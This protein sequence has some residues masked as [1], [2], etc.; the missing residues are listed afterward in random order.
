MARKYLAI[1]LLVL[2][3]ARGVT[4]QNV[5]DRVFRTG[6]SPTTSNTISLPIQEATAADL[7]SP[8]D[9]GLYSQFIQI[10]GDMNDFGLTMQL[11]QSQDPNDFFQLNEGKIPDGQ[12]TGVQANTNGV[13]LTLIRAIDRET[14]F[15]VLEF[16]MVCLPRGSSTSS[17]Y[18]YRIDIVD[19]NDNTPVFENTPYSVSVNELTPV[20]TTVF[21]DISATDEDFGENALID[22]TIVPGD[23][24]ELDGSTKFAI[25]LER[26]GYV[27]VKETLDFELLNKLGQTTYTM[28]IRAT[29]HALNELER[30]SVETSFDVTITDGDDL[31]PV[32]DYTT[33]KKVGERCLNP[34]Y[35]AT[36]ITG[37]NNNNLAITPVPADNPNLPISIIAYGQDTLDTPILFSIAYT[38]PTGY[39]NYFSV[40]TQRLAPGSKN[41]QAFIQQNQ[42]LDR[43]VFDKQS[44]EIILKAE[45]QTDQKRFNRA[46]ITVNIVLSNLFA[47]TLESSTGQLIGQIEEGRPSGTPVRGL[48]GIELMKFNVVDQDLPDPTQGAYSLEVQGTTLFVLNNDQYLVLAVNDLDYEVT[49]S[50][51][52][53]IVVKELDTEE[54]LSGTI[55]VT[56][57]VIDINDNKPVFPTEQYEGS[58]V[59]GNYASSPNLLLRVTAT[60]GDFGSNGEIRY[61]IM[62]VSN[63]GKD[64]FS[65]SEILGDIS[66][67]G[68]V[69]AGEVY[70][71]AV[72]AEDQAADVLDR[73][74]K[75]VLVK[76][77]V[78]ASGNKGPQIPSN[79]YD[80]RVSE[81]VPLNFEVITIPASDPEGDTLTFNII[82]FTTTDFVI[83]NN[84]VVTNAVLLDRERVSEYTLDI[85]V[86]D[87]SNNFA[88][89][90]LNIIVL[91]INDNSPLFGGPYNFN[92]DE[93]LSNEF[94]GTVNAGDADEQGTGR[95]QV[96]YRLQSTLFT[97]NSATGEIRTVQP[98]DYE[99]Q[100][101]HILDVQALDSA[102]DARS[103]FVKVTVN[104]NDVQDSVPLFTQDLYEVSVP[105]GSVGA[106]VTTVEAFDADL[107]D[108]ISYEFKSGDFSNF[109]IN[110]FSGL[111]T[112]DGALDFESRQ[113]YE[114]VVTTTD[115]SNSFELSSSAIV[116]VTV[117]DQNDASP[118]ISAFNAVIEILETQ[119]YGFVIVDIDATDAD[120]PNTP[121]SMIQYSILSVQPNQGSGYF[122]IDQNTGVLSVA[123]SLK[124][125]TS[126]ETEY[127]IDILAS[128]QGSPKK[129][130]SSTVTVKVIRNNSPV[131]PNSMTVNIDHLATLN[132]PILEDFKATDPDTVPP[133]NQ[134]S[135]RLIGDTIGMKYFSVNSNTG[136][137]TVTDQLTKETAKTFYLRIVASDGGGMSSTGTVTINVDR[138]LETPTWNGGLLFDSINIVENYPL[139]RMVYQFS[140]LDTDFLSP[141]NVVDYTIEGDG[142]ALSYFMISDGGILSLAQS[143]ATTNINEF[144][145]RVRICD[146]GDPQ[147]CNPD[148]FELTVNID[149]NLQPP[150]YFN[151]TYRVSVDEFVPINTDVVRVQ[152]TDADTRTEF[153]QV[154]YSI[155]G[156]DNSPS[157]FNI[158]PITGQITL[159]D[160][161]ENVPTGV[162]TIVVQAKDNG[163]PARVATS[164]VYV[165]VNRNFNNPT[166]PR[167][168]Y[169]KE[170]NENHALGTEVITITATDADKQAP[171]NEVN[172]RLI[173]VTNGREYF[174]I[175]PE[176]GMISPK[177]ALYADLTR[178]TLYTLNVEAYDLGSPQR[179]SITTATVEITVY[180]NSAPSFG[181]ETY[182]VT[183]NEDENIGAS[184]LGL[185]A[186]DVDSFKGIFGQ[187]SYRIIGLEQ[188]PSFFTIN[189]ATG[190]I[191]LLQSLLNSDKYSFIVTVEVSD[192][193]VPQLTDIATVFVT[194]N[195]NFN[196][197][198]FVR[199]NIAVEI[200]ELRPL[201]SVIETIRATDSDRFPPNNQVVYTATGTS[202]ALTYF[203]VDAISGDISVIR[204]LTL[205]NALTYTLT[206]IASDSGEPKLQTAVPVTVT[207]TV[208][209]NQ[210]APVFVNLPEEMSIVKTTQRFSTVFTVE[211]T[212]RDT[213]P[214]YNTITYAIVSGSGKE[215]FD[216]NPNTG[217]ITLRED[218]TLLS[219]SSYL[220]TIR[221]SDGGS[222]PKTAFSFLTF[223]VDQNLQIPVWINPGAGNT[224]RDVITI[225]ETV[226]FQTLIYNAN[227][228]DTD[229]SSPFNLLDYY[230]TG[231]GNGPTY[232]TINPDNGE[233]RLKSSLIADTA[234]TYELTIGVKDRGNPPRDSNQEITLTINV[235]R[236]KFGPQWRNLPYAGSV[237]QSVSI[238]DSVLAVTATDA[239]TPLYN[240]V[241]Y[242]IFGDD[243]APDYFEINPNNGI[244]SVKQK[245]DQTT[246][247]TFTLRVRAVDNGVPQKENVTTVTFTINHNLYPPTIDTTNVN[248]R[249][250]E[251]Q[252]LGVAIAKVEATDR[253][254][255]P[256]HNLVRYFMAAN[257]IAEEF[258]SV[259]EIT[260]EIT[261][262]KSLLVDVNKRST[263]TF[264]V[265]VNDLGT[266]VK[267][268]S[269]VARVTITVYRNNNAPRFTNGPYTTTISETETP[270]FSVFR[271][272]PEDPDVDAPFNQ[273]TLETIGDAPAPTYFEVDQTGLVTLINSVEQDTARQY[274]MRFS[275]VDGGNPALRA[276][277]TLT[278]IVERN[279]FN[280]V[281]SP[282][283]YNET[284]EETRILGDPILR[285][286]A[287]DDDNKSP[288]N[289]VRYVMD[290]SVASTIAREYFFVDLITGDVML[291][292]PLTRDIGKSNVYTFT[293]EAYD[294]DNPPKRSL[295][296]AQVT[297]N[298]LRNQ[299][300]PIFT[301]LPNA[302]EIDETESPNTII[303]TASAGDSDPA[304]FNVITYDMIGFGDATTAFN[305]DPN[306]GEI[307][308]IRSFLNLASTSYTLQIRA[309][310]SGNP[311]LADYETLTVNIKRNFFKP[312]FLQPSY[313]ITIL[314]TYTVDQSVISVSANDGDRASPNNEIRYSLNLV[315]RFLID[316]ATGL[317]KVR[318]SLLG[319]SQSSFVYQVTATDKGTPALSS[320][321]IEVTIR[322]IRNDNPPEILNLPDT[323]TINSNQNQFSSIFTVTSRDNDTRSPFNLLS[324]S[325]IGDDSAVNL[326]RISQSGAIS[327]SSSLN[328]ENIEVYKVRVRVQDGGTLP[329]DAVAVLTVKVTRNLAAPEFN[330]AVYNPAPIPETFELGDTVV[331][332]TATDADLQSPNNVVEYTLAGD[333]RAKEYFYI[334]T[335]TGHISVT[336]PLY[337][338]TNRNAPYRLTITGR[339]LGDPS[340]DATNTATV[341]ISVNRNNNPPEFL[342]TPYTG[343]LDY[344]APVGLSLAT[345][346]TRDLDTTSPFKDVTVTVIGDG[347]AESLFNLDG[348]II[349]LANSVD[350]AADTATTYKLRLL[351]RD[352]GNPSLTA[353][354]TVVINVNRN[355]NSPIFSPSSYNIRVPDNTP[356]GTIVTTVTATDADPRSPEKDFDYESVGDRFALEY[357]S[358][359][360]KSGEI[361]LLKTLVGVNINQFNYQIAAVDKGTPSRSG[362]TMVTITVIRDPD[363]LSFI[364]TDYVANIPETLSVG[365]SV[366]N[367][368]A[369][370]GPGITYAISSFSAA[371]DYFDLDP[372]TGLIT[373][374]KDLRE[375]PAR[376]TFYFLRVSASKQFDVN[377]QTVH[378]NVSITVNRNINEPQFS[379][380]IYRKTIPQSQ[381]PGSLVIQLLATDNDQQ[382][383][384]QYTLIDT[385][386]ES[387]LFYVKPTSGELS[388]GSTLTGTTKSE[389]R[390]SVKVS[391]QST[392]EKT[393][394]ALVIITVTRNQFSPQFTGNLPYSTGILFNAAVDTSVFQ[395]RAEDQDIEGDMV[396]GIDGFLSGMS[397]FRIDPNT[398]IIYLRNSLAADSPLQYTV[399]LFAYDSAWPNDR[400]HTNLTISINR[401]PNAPSFI[402][403]SYLRT[404]NESYPLG[405]SLVQIEA[406]DLDG[407][408]LTYIITSTAPQDGL[409]YFYLNPFTGMLSVR[410]PLDTTQSD[411]YTLSVQL[412]DNG[413]P[414]RRSISQAS[415]RI[416]I[417]RNEYCPV[418]P[419]NMQTV[420]S[421]NDA[422]T[423]SI[424][425]AVATD[426][427]PQNSQYSLITY[428]LLGDGLTQNFFSV[429][430]DNG[431]INIIRDLTSDDAYFYTARVLASDGGNPPC[432]AT[433]LLTINVRRNLNPPVF[434]QAAY[435]VEIYETHQLS[436]SVIRVSA[437]DQDR[438][439]PENTVVYESVDTTR[440]GLGDQ[441]FS[442]DTATGVYTVK[443]PLYE[444]GTDTDAYTFR[445]T[446]R[447]S[448]T[449]VQ[450][451]LTQATV[452]INVLRNRNPPIFQNEPY[453]ATVSFNVQ[454]GSPVTSDVSATDAD[455]DPFRTITYTIIGDGEADTL[456]SINPNTAAISTRTTL[457][458]STLEA[459][460]IR[461]VAS[462]S[463][464]PALKD[465]ATVLV[466][467]S[468]NLND[469]I[470][471]VADYTE[472]ILE[473]QPFG[474]PFMVIRG[475]DSDVNAPYNT[476]VFTITG[477]S[478]FQNFFQINP[479]TGEIY[480]IKN[481][482]DTTID[483]FTTSVSLR[484]DG[485]PSR[486]AVSEASV[487][488]NIIRNDNTPYFLNIPYFKN[489]DQT[490]NQG[491]SILT[492]T[493]RDNDPGNTPF[494]TVRFMLVGDDSAPTYFSIDE[495]SGL[496]RVKQSLQAETTDEFRIRIRAYDLGEPSRFN[497]T[498]AI[499]TVTQNFQS[500]IFSPDSYTVTIY[501]TDS[502]GDVVVQV[503]ATDSDPL[504]PNNDVSYEISQGPED[505][506]CFIINKKTGEITIKRSFLYDPCKADIYEMTI[507]A[508]D[509]GVPSRPSSNNAA[510]TVNVIRNRNP[511]RFT[512][513]PFTVTSGV[514]ENL[515]QGTSIYDANA[516]DSDPN[517]FNV[518]T[519]KLLGPA[520][521]LNSFDVDSSTGEVSLKRSLLQDTQTEYTLI[522]QAADSGSPSLSD[523][524][525]L[526]VNVQRNLNDPVFRDLEYSITIDETQQVGSSILAVS[527]TDSDT[528]DP[529]NVVTYRPIGSALA[530]QYFAINE[531]TGIVS[532]R[533]PL[534]NDNADTLQYTMT[535]RAVD[536][537]TPPRQSQQVATVRIT[538]NRNQNCPVF[539]NLPDSV[540]IDQS[541]GSN[542]VASIRATDSDTAGTI[543][544]NIEYALIGAGSGQILFTIDSQSGDIRSVP[545]LFTD[546]GISYIL[547]IEATNGAASDCSTTGTL[548]VTVNRNLNAP[549][550][551]RTVP[552]N[553]NN[554]E[555]TILETHSSLPVY[556]VSATDSDVRP[557]NNVVNYRFDQFSPNT[558]IF[559]VES[560]TGQ[561]FLKISLLGRTENSYEVFLIAYDMGLP[562]QVSE[563]SILTV[564]VRRNNFPPEILNL[565]VTESIR[566][567]I[568]AGRPILTVQARDNDTVSPFNVLSYMIIGDDDAA[569]FFN[570]VPG[571]G[572]ITLRQSILNEPKD[573]YSIRVR[574]SDGGTQPKTDTELLTV[575]V[576]RNLN[577]PFFVGGPYR[578]QILENQPL[579]LAILTARA[580]DQ[581]TVSPHKD[582]LFFLETTDQNIEDFFSVEATS[583]IIS[584]RR[585]MLE[586]PNPANTFI[587]R[588]ELSARDM[589][590][591]S[592]AASTNAQVE[593]TVIRNTPPEF[594]GTIAYSATVTL[595]SRPGS[596]V[597]QTRA[598]DADTVAPFNQIT[599]SMIGDDQTPSLFEIN[600]QTGLIS[601]RATADL[602]ADSQVEYIARVQVSDGGSPILFDTATVQ[603]TVQR[604]LASPVFS[605]ARDLSTTIP[606]TMPPGDVVI[607][608]NASDADQFA[609]NNLI[610][611]SIIGNN[612]D[613]NFFF[614]DQE[615]GV[616]TLRKSVLNTGKNLYQLRVQAS[617]KGG[618][619]TI[620][621]HQC[622][623]QCVE[624]YGCLDYA[625]T[626]CHHQRE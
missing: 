451:T 546:D 25:D 489:V 240:I 94:V 468:R 582:V 278:I 486:F 268:S 482:R 123:R 267:F 283:F 93:G 263:F 12:Y 590:S 445:V 107:T 73:R 250:P 182:Y 256:P 464:T 419:N 280:P 207:I 22:F 416:N 50:V 488:V 101:Q 77:T 143:P 309:R 34:E 78:T 334:E 42:A 298:V 498:V 459:Y 349:K 112:V 587:V 266:P 19:I 166:W 241:S 214:P 316:P 153:N 429:N 251:T 391:D 388:L 501:E 300:P 586:Y 503:T 28:T 246:R 515:S 538:V 433:G 401:N 276:I 604:N 505:L 186:T 247:P 206:A 517:P 111:I 444:D 168:F 494:G 513:L 331:I 118:I 579:G 448:G 371:T 229:T 249:I 304:P 43:A 158:N 209:R 320:D 442:F 233:I 350:L 201:G 120:P 274:V 208:T 322:I 621:Q 439:A 395:A 204:P 547:L 51:S 76:V 92:V 82:S 583:G 289:T 273:I 317:I 508:R 33:C 616:I 540:S 106:I 370:P 157:Y 219:P 243:S 21:R 407:H 325:I 312:A 69:I 329:K 148:Q 611:Y 618:S 218:L 142:N 71:I 232:F 602:T 426:N 375:D 10:Y 44:V 63:D 114:F 477:N 446:A 224:Y 20:G 490:L 60:D 53:N 528:K 535:V 286:T 193:G 601:L 9:P 310:D 198:D 130:A 356:S 342:N 441:F 141:D 41:F 534:T 64:K 279:L 389:Y 295:L 253:D 584:L 222:P 180:R 511:P 126:R 551:Q 497:D 345:F 202:S 496:I 588:F 227:A 185:T 284:I 447:D 366:R 337:M 271:I 254:I 68:N 125:D 230:I 324:Y 30:R 577:A 217:E 564:N 140:G 192:D 562:S 26:Q 302:I 413:I 109:N 495:Q 257:T 327:L 161:L 155:I 225:P 615:S 175:D 260:G 452:T 471:L 84:G 372:T 571:S 136:I 525:I 173:G 37:T 430:Q 213:V 306:T 507:S 6:T 235:I 467:V 614:I 5:C 544:S 282:R 456:F 518:I 353:T 475:Q 386:G 476:L 377:L 205:D 613:P 578:E 557:P 521:A 454:Q 344:T 425:Q 479:S 453:S 47:P 129:T 593:I 362:S 195:R 52:F 527:A 39:D 545:G 624:R 405:V 56:V 450:S 242:S 8:P 500:P 409:E 66:V 622:G 597:F 146:K 599:Y 480:V 162:F 394:T 137:I 269:S 262:R 539:T 55:T 427:D 87:Q 608:V 626:I 139:S 357:F 14:D 287:T 307:R 58:V 81:G 29:D 381:A 177:I 187:M 228:S 563:R 552:A 281:F 363:Q 403:A 103:T 245:L 215:E 154:T 333:D 110:Q 600:D 542:L 216:I 591:P 308:L 226:D 288:Y 321:P 97:I 504:K 116:R 432:T 301:N 530:L 561:V 376:Q 164:L 378:A 510:V 558:D 290:Q 102:P 619:N 133:F 128:D 23:G 607:N 355:L 423:T 86:Q 67:T 374:K 31:G 172:Y 57:N 411:T 318:R 473:T 297:I 170:I 434:T 410:K 124:E 341:T 462:D 458:L 385:P 532:V 346:V 523:T 171:N 13:F 625:I 367:V 609:P 553:T 147:K 336:K 347:I 572:Q 332:V 359:N 351:A 181:Q 408:E 390:F 559:T 15:S 79:R 623:C 570:I 45:E 40:T 606:E 121:N 62:S 314:E 560:G 99:T 237:S 95:S 529:H 72:Q 138:N 383:V 474:V 484:D 617:D 422:T 566:Q 38:N 46:T 392:P 100:T 567:D 443:Y 594:Q 463:G 384:L 11:S 167:P 548:I 438:K 339:D 16:T 580:N 596:S 414:P 449:P 88:D 568:T 368:V 319:E 573:S 457:A 406:T 354:T 104:V 4:T 24:T 380:A 328:N 277:T 119:P 379:E 27:T 61:S 270:G 440:G 469:P 127:T 113:F 526:V 483:T 211:A 74:S 98:L 603:I 415:V 176:T 174:H 203:H 437:P 151:S 160:S 149:R 291:K 330:P 502:L 96:T 115:G 261:V 364:T 234:E 549:E 455:P 436:N 169:S 200:S 259:N 335:F 252:S 512:N 418:F 272:S 435:E 163:S 212:D 424:Y 165:T 17:Y 461:V 197:P 132:T 398:G 54:L 292:V 605:P 265:N 178:E 255:Q 466:T 156:D 179:Q 340:L 478:D 460:S 105:E 541:Q 412:A 135:Y 343:R 285:V 299:N 485:K 303:Y 150:I 569:A 554:Y 311:R 520:V 210:F 338:D 592:Q 305:V 315:D 313:E 191:T 134:I 264:D 89:T 533:R 258:F 18:T 387:D 492:A 421:E 595:N 487:T 184:V 75:S 620:S 65:I 248:V 574:V 396:Y 90:Q 537:G 382:D 417:Q 361:Y 581:D 145:V 221:A 293:V 188:A 393:S 373:V 7:V 296:P 612:D 516:V 585:S 231:V 402:E 531:D 404:V 220:L 236:N 294:G 199:K 239:D 159:I 589:G 465:T 223:I 400:A 131:V 399:G 1:P 431:V 196:A 598:S 85:R 348:N 358:L 550:W 108:D 36:V 80:V 470:F 506:E 2:V 369:Q 576:E 499:V 122:T 493:A 514:T 144:L 183:V 70:I 524:E 397:Y 326:F 556:T 83:D 610:S 509:D 575:T 352:G 117:L 555:V 481:L 360:S 323:V 32:F 35:S 49:Q 3:I 543:F 244:I 491:V 59:E 91:D 275:A 420:I 190:E 365:S 519:Y 152:A 536:K 522:L 48:N 189:S 565:P 428:A 194:V 472:R 238:G